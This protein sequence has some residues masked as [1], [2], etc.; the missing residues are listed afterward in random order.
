MKVKLSS[1][2][3]KPKYENPNTESVDLLFL[4]A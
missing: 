1:A 3:Q 2:E 4:F